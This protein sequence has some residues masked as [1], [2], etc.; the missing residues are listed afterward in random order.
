MVQHTRL[1]QFKDDQEHII[2]H[3]LYGGCICSGTTD[4]SHRADVAMF[5]ETEDDRFSPLD[6]RALILCGV[7]VYHPLW[8]ISQFI[9]HNEESL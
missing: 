8:I 6:V 1:D 4:R 9:R 2:R 5:F 3:V 7:H